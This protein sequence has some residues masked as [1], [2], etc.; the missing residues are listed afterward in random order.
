LLCS[1]IVGGAHQK[2]VYHGRSKNT[3]QL[4]RT[5]YVMLFIA[6]PS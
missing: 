2:K 6:Q 3:E 1:R 5:G 4:L